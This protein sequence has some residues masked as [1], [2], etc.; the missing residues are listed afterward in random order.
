ML[1]VVE[2]QHRRRRPEPL[3]NGRGATSWRHPH[4]QRTGD[5]GRDAGWHRDLG[6][7]D[8]QLVADECLPHQPRLARTTRAD[9]RRHAVVREGGPQRRQLTG[10]ADEA[11]DGGGHPRSGDALCQRGWRGW[12][13]HRGRRVERPVTGQDPLLQLVDRRTG[14]DAVL[15]GDAFAEGT[16]HGQRV[17]RPAGLVQ[18]AHQQQLRTFSQR[19]GP[20]QG[21]DLGQ[22]DRRVARLQTT[23]QPLLPQLRPPFRQAGDVGDEGQPV[24]DVR[25]RVAPPHVERGRQQVRGRACV[26]SPRRPHQALNL[27][28]VDRVIRQVQPVARRLADDDRPPVCRRSRET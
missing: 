12:R 7:L 5:G 20:R 10:A 13:G 9:D 1:A 26:A 23:G 11:V 22:G 4:A 24:G 21:I 18:R 16:A 14:V 3:D 6:Q 27:R 25:Q 17:G 19:F 2:H 8:D 15:L 28:D